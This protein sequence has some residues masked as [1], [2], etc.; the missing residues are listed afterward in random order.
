MDRPE[1]LYIPGC[2]LKKASRARLVPGLRIE[3]YCDELC[4]KCGWHA[5]ERERR[6]YMVRHGGLRYRPDGTRGLQLG[7]DADPCAHCP[8]KTGGGHG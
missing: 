1:P 8:V 5:A 7:G 6:A 2:E 4:D 3:D